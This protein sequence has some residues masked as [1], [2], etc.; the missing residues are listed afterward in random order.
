MIGYVGLTLIGAISAA[1]SSLI[2]FDGG[3]MVTASAY[4]LGGLTGFVVCFGL[5]LSAADPGAGPFYRS[6]GYE[7]DL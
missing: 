2:F 3:L 6:R 7:W 5:L 4:M 1:L